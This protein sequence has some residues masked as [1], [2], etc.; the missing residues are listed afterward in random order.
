MY[1]HSDPIG[2]AAPNTSTRT[3]EQPSEQPAATDARRVRYTV[4][5]TVMTVV[6]NGWFAQS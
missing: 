6:M 3:L 4:P 2:T 1:A 5:S